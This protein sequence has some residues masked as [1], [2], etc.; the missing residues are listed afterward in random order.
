MALPWGMMKVTAEEMGK[1]LPD[2]LAAVEKGET[3]II[4]RDSMPVAE[5]KPV[6][7]TKPPFRTN[8]RLVPVVFVEDPTKPLAPE[9]WP[10]S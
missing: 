3:V 5:L 9:D 8:P 1:Q 7:E 6:P 10:E 4:C 2:L